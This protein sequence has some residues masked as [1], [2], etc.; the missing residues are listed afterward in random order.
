MKACW[1][2]AEQQRQGR[3]GCAAEEPGHRGVVERGHVAPV[4]RTEVV[5]DL[6]RPALFVRALRHQAR[7]LKGRR[8][9]AARPQEAHADRPVIGTHNLGRAHP[10]LVGALRPTREL[11][12]CQKDPLHRRSSWKINDGMPN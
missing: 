1:P 9:R 6:D 7:N 8:G 5:A 2:I 10:V 3:A 12:T 4:D 11:P